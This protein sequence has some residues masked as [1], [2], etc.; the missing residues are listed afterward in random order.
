MKAVEK[1]NQVSG[2]YGQPAHY[3]NSVGILNWS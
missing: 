2:E 3:I 1:G